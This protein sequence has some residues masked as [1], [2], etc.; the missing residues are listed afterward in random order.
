VWKTKNVNLLERFKAKRNISEKKKQT[1]KIISLRQFIAFWK[2]S[3][4]FVILFWFLNRFIACQVASYATSCNK[5]FYWH[6]FQLIQFVFIAQE[7]TKVNFKLQNFKIPFWYVSFG[8]RLLF[9][10]VHPSFY[11]V[12]NRKPSPP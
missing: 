8:K 2:V 1:N 9:F 5:F 12:S 6:L 3:L 10:A 11:I 7:S 4:P